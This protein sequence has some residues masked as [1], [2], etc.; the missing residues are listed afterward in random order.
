VFH[1][2]D[3]AALV[4]SRCLLSR[5]EGQNIASEI[6]KARENLSEEGCLIL[7]FRAVRFAT[8]ASLTE[9]FSIAATCLRG[10]GTHMHIFLALSCNNRDLKQSIVHALKIAKSLM[11]SFDDAGFWDVLGSP[12]KA[13]KDTFSLITKLEEITSAKLS[14]LL[15]ISVNAACNRLLDLYNLRL[16]RRTERLLGETGGREY[17]YRPVIEIA[18]ESGMYELG[19]LKMLMRI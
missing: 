3:I 5:E 19:H 14:K 9:I 7:D 11:L 4:P 2:I 13:Q 15:N 17:V 8:F 1:K 10:I 16:I 18:S 12:T 6:A